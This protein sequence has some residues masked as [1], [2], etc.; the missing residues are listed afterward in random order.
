MA[1]QQKL[2]GFHEVAAAADGR[3]K[4]D[5]NTE[6]GGAAVSVRTFASPVLGKDARAVK[7]DVLLR[8]ALLSEPKKAPPSKFQKIQGAILPVVV[9]V[10]IIGLIVLL[11]IINSLHAQ[12]LSTDYICNDPCTLSVVESIPVGLTFH[13]GPHHVSTYDSWMDLINSSTASID[14]ASFYWTLRPQDV[15]NDSSGQ[16]GQNV[17]DAIANAGSRRGIKIRIV[18]DATQP[19]QEVDYLANAGAADVRKV[20]MTALLGA[21][22]V[23]TKF[24]VVDKQ[25]FYVGSANMDWRSL[26]QV[27]EL[28]ATVKDCACMAT[29]L[30]RVFEIYWMMGVPGAQLPPSWPSRLDTRY[31]ASMPL[32]VSFEGSNDTCGVFFSSSPPPFSTPSRADDAATIVTT[33]TSANRSVCIAVMDYSPTTLYMPHG[34]NVF[35]PVIDDAIRKAAFERHVTVR[36]LTSLWI[37]HTDESALN[38]LESLT[39]FHRNIY[40]KMF[41]VPSNASQA[42]IPFARVNHNKYMVTDNVAYIG[43][44]NWA[45]DYFINT[46]GVAMVANE[47]GNDPAAYG[48]GS[49]GSLRA[50]LQAV[51]DR[52]WFSPY[53]L[54]FSEARRRLKP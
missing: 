38:Y 24:I 52:D 21:G 10:I 49:S 6:L 17:F 45:G 29:D 40:A 16:Q 50:Q 32:N 44:S 23:H 37:N 9:L 14:I 26:T 42:E 43:T 36:M 8:E 41:L 47:T 31:N 33:I 4:I 46:A 7:S 20:N 51:F 19:T 11:F 13:G 27:K 39:F 22:V 2:G 25:H 48:G 30:L 15:F 5:G 3:P 12:S 18:Q 1:D 28:G 53:A 34:H 54:N 35:W